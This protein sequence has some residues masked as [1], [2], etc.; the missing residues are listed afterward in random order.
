MARRGWPV[1][2]VRLRPHRDSDTHTIDEVQLAP[3]IRGVA[4]PVLRELDISSDRLR[5]RDLV[6]LLDDLATIRQSAKI[7]E[8]VV[9]VQAPFWRPLAE[10]LHQRFGWPVVYDRMDRHGAFST[11]GSWT[12]EEER[13][14]FAASHGVTVSARSLTPPAAAQDP[15]CTVIPNACCPSDWEQAAVSPELDPVPRPRIGYFGAIA[16]WVDTELIL[17]LALERPQWS[18]VLVGST[19][20][21]H[22][23]RL[24]QLDNVFFLG[25]RPYSELP[26]LAAG[27][28]IGIIPF[29]RSALTDSADPI[30]AY[31]MLAAGLEV[32]AT[33]LPELEPIGDLIRRADS[34]SRFLHE[35]EDALL[36]PKS[37]AAVAARRRFARANSW[38]HRAALLEA[39]VEATFPLVSVA[40]VTHDNLELTKLCIESLYRTTVYPRFEVIVVD[41]ASADATLSWLEKEAQR[42]PNLRVFGNNHNAGFAAANNRAFREATGEI[43]CLLNNDTVVTQGWL[44]ALVRTLR[45][46]PDV[47]LVGPSTNGSA[48]AAR[49]TAG[50]SDL[51]ELDSWAE[52]FVWQHDG[53][54]FPVPGLA[55][56]CAALRRE[57]WE[58]VGGLDE[59]FKVGM[60]EDDD[61]C[62]RLLNAG[63]E[64]R[65]LRSAWIHHF[66]QA[67]FANLDAAEYARIYEANRKRFLEKWRGNHKRNQS[68]LHNTTGDA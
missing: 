5:E 63:Y 19:W 45:H 13:R 16:E 29:R 43:F 9:L 54:S 58:Q 20:S 42:R 11:A 57:V 12:E 35:I 30:K 40:I 22:T 2:Y 6:R 17:A 27:F 32:V 37:A 14:L 52:Q 25:E 26:S 49:V 1:L 28:D 33:P 21:G 3:G 24:E 59:R 48:D 8:G 66:Q 39:A 65:C 67:T 60:F 38:D 36:E 34:T 46:D 64:I 4:L 31:E 15:P 55:L 23:A 47:G 50:Y 68:N 51:S 62:R 61:L 41:N 7:H 44:C 10:R 18:F 53:D 56:H